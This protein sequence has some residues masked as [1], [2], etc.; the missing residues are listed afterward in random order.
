[1][2]ELAWLNG[3]LLPAAEVLIPATDRGF[4]LGDGLFETLRL[5][6]G[7]VRDT[8]AHFARLAAGAKLLRLP[9]PFDAAA[10]G[11]ILTETAAANHLRDGGL[12]LT[13]TRGP[14]P[15]GLPP[16]ISPRPTVLV[17]AFAPPARAVEIAAII[18]TSIARDEASPLSRVKTLNYLPNILARLE[19]Q[20]RGAEEAILLNHAGR[21]AGASIGNILVRAGGIWL[22]PPV[23]EG[24][25]PG[26]RRARLLASGKVR[27]AP[28]DQDT[29]RRA[30]SL[31]VCNVLA[32]RP[33]TAL[34]GATL[35]AAP[36]DDLAGL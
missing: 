9:L 5:Q 27:Q 31:C 24:A 29:L 23:T 3:R 14:G 21:I 34:E 13:L 20:E 36:V 19:A 18:A 28:I 15:R 35:P 26:I 4:T 33:I 7:T 1:M 10:M 16:P 6:D 8:P 22:T 17:S 32:L 12:R 30:T 25:L 11:A 2:A